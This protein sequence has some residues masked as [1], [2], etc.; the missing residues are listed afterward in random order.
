MGRLAE[1]FSSADL[2][3]LMQ[4]WHSLLSADPISLD[5]LCDLPYPPFVLSADLTQRSDNDYFDGH[6]LALYLVSTGQFTHPVSR[7][8]ITREECAA[9]D[10][11]IRS[12]AITQLRAEAA[13]VLQALFRGEGAGPGSRQ[14]EPVPRWEGGL[15]VLDDDD[16]PS[17]A[18]NVSAYVQSTDRKLR[19]LL[20]FR[21]SLGGHYVVHRAVLCGACQ[22]PALLLRQLASARLA[23]P[24][25]AGG[26][27]SSADGAK[28]ISSAGSS[29]RRHHEAELAREARELLFALACADYIAPDASE[30]VLA[31]AAIAAAAAAPDA[32]AE[33]GHRPKAH[34]LKVRRWKPML[35]DAAAAGDAAKVGELLA[36]GEDPTLRHIAFGFK[37]PYDVSA[38]GAT[39]DAFR[40]FCGASPGAWNWERAH[41]PSGLTEAAEEERREAA[42]G[43]A[44]AEAQAQL[45][46]LTC[47]RRVALR[48]RR[49]RA[50]EA[51]L[52]LGGLSEAQRRFLLGEDW[53]L[54]VAAPAANAASTPREDTA[55]MAGEEAATSVALSYRGAT[56]HVS[57]L[58]C[59]R[60]SG[61]F[62]QTARAFDLPPERYGL[63]LLHKGKALAPDATVGLALSGAAA[64]KLMVLAS[65]TDAVRQLQAAKSDTSVAS[66]AAEHGSRKGKVPVVVGPRR[67]RKS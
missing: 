33:R 38:D 18:E 43:E 12:P 28:H 45:A 62:E 48:A 29:L 60:V 47:P 41:V 15:A 65:A 4:W 42:H 61:L 53:Q 40:R 16:A 58:P 20:A 66:F 31:N 37:V 54:A 8:Q 6:I 59:G 46:A 55:G 19:P 56:V 24:V 26:R 51:S 57:V 44:V 25:W 52:R 17:H 34:V 13:L 23:S 35:H 1:F 5:P 50:A 30:E 32:E 64:P 36:G 49:R 2:Y 22:E 21:D 63:K 10:R 27:Q 3:A 67:G 39:R 7:R 11:I 9:L 14:P